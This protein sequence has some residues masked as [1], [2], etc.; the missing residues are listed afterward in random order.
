MQSEKLDKLIFKAKHIEPVYGVIKPNELY[1]VEK[2]LDVNFPFDFKYISLKYSYEYINFF[3]TYSFP[4]GVIE[5]TKDWRKNIKLPVNYIALGDNGSSTILMK[6]ENDINI[7]WTALEDVLNIC[8]NQ[9]FM[10][11][12]TIFSSFTDF[13]EYLLNEEEKM[14]AEEAELNKKTN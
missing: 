13:F 9:K 6:I 1:M 2:E 7:I 4:F 5:V 10:H 12:P 8:N 11:N 14:K 3:D